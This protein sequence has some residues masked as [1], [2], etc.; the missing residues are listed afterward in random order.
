MRLIL[1][2]RAL[3]FV[4]RGEFER[5]LKQM[6]NDTVTEIQTIKQEFNGKWQ[7][8]SDRITALEAALA[9]GGTVSPE[10][11]A[12]LDDLKQTVEGAQVPA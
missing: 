3:A 12:A 5:R 4:T 9:A 7:A 10:V 1:T 6:A 11:Q 2:L 8:A